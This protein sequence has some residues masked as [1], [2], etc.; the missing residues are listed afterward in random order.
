M[1]DQEQAAPDTAEAAALGDTLQQLGDDAHA[2]VRA[3]LGALQALRTL[4]VADVALARAA[5]AHALVYGGLAIALGGSCW[6]L[7]MAALVAGLQQLG[8]SWLLALL[9]AAGLSLA[10]TLLAAWGAA[11]QFRHTGL[12]ATRRQLAQWA[13]ALPESL[14]RD[15]GTG[16]A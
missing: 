12:Q 2:S 13:A 7:L 14:H 3:T 5:L 6:L 9:L 10:G 15:D 1:S 16:A 11:R 4:A 8:V